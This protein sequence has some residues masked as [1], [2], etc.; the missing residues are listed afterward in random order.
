FAAG[1]TLE[2]SGLS[3][4]LLAQGEE[5]VPFTDTFAPA[6]PAAGAAPPPPRFDP[7]NLK[8]FI[9]PNDQFF[10]VQHYNVP[11]VD[12]ATY[13]LRIGGLVE[14]PIELSLADIKK[15]PRVEH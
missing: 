10:A 2:L 1:V 6:P 9:V 3:L 7:R 12:A 13:S 11:K 4:P 14:K 5:V 15:R 8:E